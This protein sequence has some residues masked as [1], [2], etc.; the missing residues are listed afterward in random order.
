MGRAG[1]LAGRQAGR[2]RR[3]EELYTALRVR[4][5]LGSTASGVGL[6]FGTGCAWTAPRGRRDGGG[7]RGGS[8]ASGARGRRDGN[9]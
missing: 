4:C 8:A 2:Q 7:K 1:K 3:I 9:E 6:G 5:A